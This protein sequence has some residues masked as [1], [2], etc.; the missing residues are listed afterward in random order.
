MAA[1]ENGADRMAAMEK[2]SQRRLMAVT[3]PM[4]Y[5]THGPIHDISSHWHHERNSNQLQFRKNPVRE[6]DSNLRM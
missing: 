5:Y 2:N 6:A 3:C 4:S 1:K